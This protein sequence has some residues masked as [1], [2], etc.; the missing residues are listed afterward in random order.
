MSLSQKPFLL[1]R[2]VNLLSENSESYFYDNEKDINV[3]FLNGTATPSVVSGNSL[4]TQSK[5]C[6][7]PGDDDPD[8]EAENCY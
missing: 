4:T 6:S 3:S 8:R 2:S 7:A 5:T 1:A